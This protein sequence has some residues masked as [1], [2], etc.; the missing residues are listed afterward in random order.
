MQVK[1]NAK[2]R[3]KLA[4]F[5]RGGAHTPKK[6]WAILMSGTWQILKYP[7]AGSKKTGAKN[8]DTGNLPHTL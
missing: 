1:K 7:L 4:H 3:F 5:F 8:V 6:S 2:H